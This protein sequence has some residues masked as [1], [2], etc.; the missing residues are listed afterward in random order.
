MRIS[1]VDT[2]LYYIP[3]PAV[4]TDAMHGEMR[5]FAVA[6]VQIKTDSGA[7]GLGYTYI[8]GGH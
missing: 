7:E 8:G 5:H 2:R 1:S 3:L 4:L 6:T